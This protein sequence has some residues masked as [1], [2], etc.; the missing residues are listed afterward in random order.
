M[1]TTNLYDFATHPRSICKAF[2]CFYQTTYLKL[3]KT[4]QYNTRNILRK[5]YFGLSFALI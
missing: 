4:V 2:I 3:N 5:S 1:P